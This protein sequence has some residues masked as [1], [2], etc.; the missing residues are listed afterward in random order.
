MSS[1]REDPPRSPEGDN[2]GPG[3]AGSWEGVVASEKGF[4][5]EKQRGRVCSVGTEG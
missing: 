2:I 3:D 5:S 1:H 4:H